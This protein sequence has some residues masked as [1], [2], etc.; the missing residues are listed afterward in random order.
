MMPATCA[1][2][3]NNPGSAE[4]GTTDGVGMAVVVA[5]GERE[6]DGAALCD[7]RHGVVRA[8][9]A[10]TAATAATDNAAGLQRARLRLRGGGGP[11]RATAGDAAGR[12]GNLPEPRGCASGRCAAVS[13]RRARRLRRRQVDR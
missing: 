7:E 5:A 8:S 12:S 1:V 4:T 2:G 6:V 3:S 9:T 11:R 10:T 13:R